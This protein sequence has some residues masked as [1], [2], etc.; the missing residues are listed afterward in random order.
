[1]TTV[2]SLG[3]IAMI[4]RVI[5]R[6]N[7]PTGYEEDMIEGYFKTI[8]D[9]VFKKIDDFRAG[10]WIYTKEATLEDLAKIAEIASLEISDIRDSLD[11]YELPRVEQIGDNLIFSYQKRENV[12]L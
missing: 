6:K 4:S 10:S 12:R 7:Q 11:K 1:M 5:R 2:R 9:T 8:R 3:A